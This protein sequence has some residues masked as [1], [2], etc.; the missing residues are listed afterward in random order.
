MPPRRRGARSDDNESKERREWYN[1]MQKKMYNREND[2][3]SLLEAQ[4]FVEDIPTNVTIGEKESEEDSEMEEDVLSEETSAPVPSFSSLALSL[5]QESLDRIEK[6][7]D[8]LKKKVE[9]DVP[10]TI[11]SELN[12]SKWFIS[13]THP[14]VIRCRLICFH[15][16][17]GTILTFESWRTIMN[18]FGIEL[19]CLNLPGRYNR[20]KE[21][22]LDHVWD[23]AA[24]AVEAYCAL[25]LHQSTVRTC[26]FGHT[27]GAVIALEFAIELCVRNLPQPSHLIVSNCVAP[28]IVTDRNDDWT[29]KKIYKSSLGT[30]VSLMFEQ[31][32]VPAIFH[33][34]RDFLESFVPHMRYD[35]M[36]LEQYRLLKKRKKRLPL[37]CGLTTVREA[38][39]DTQLREDV[40]EWE[41][42]AAYGLKQRVCIDPEEGRIFSCEGV[43]S[44]SERRLLKAIVWAC[45]HSEEKEKNESIIEGIPRQDEDLSD[46]EEE[47]CTL[48]K[49]M[50][51][52]TTMNDL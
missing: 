43:Q 2:C 39:D 6:R 33:E 8:K 13:L 49:E 5:A 31:G 47:S 16:I 35:Y 40:A 36:L 27:V 19:I 37:S 22:R 18:R 45:L 32:I 51:Y 44:V 42:V 50:F 17:A 41:E 7:N 14:T 1:M 28:Q 25:D 9:Q 10:I 26:L 30:F 34:R 20:L 29:A 3:D 48:S 12:T 46:G 52:A 21:K 11:M 23:I 38:F 15:G 24:N 4:S